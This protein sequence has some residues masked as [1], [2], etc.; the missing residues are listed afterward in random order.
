MEGATAVAIKKIRVQLDFSEEAFN[1]LN[2]LVSKL[3]APSRAEVIR[4]ALGVLKWMYK[5]KVEQGLDV[6]AIGTDERVFE[7][8]FPFLPSRK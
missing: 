8:E 1:E 6:V 4:N 5:K 3:H 7:P 2:D